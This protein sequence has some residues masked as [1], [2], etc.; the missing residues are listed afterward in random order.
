MLQPFNGNKDISAR[1]SS[2]RDAISEYKHFACVKNLLLLRYLWTKAVR[3]VLWD[4]KG[5]P[6]HS[7]TWL[8]VRELSLSMQSYN[9]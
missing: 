6:F 2:I 3:K 5:F 7:N 4:V 8:I 9:M 1:L